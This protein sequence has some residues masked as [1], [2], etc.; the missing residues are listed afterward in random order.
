MKTHDKEK[1]ALQVIDMWLDYRSRLSTLPVPGFQICIRKKNRIVFSK[2]Y[3]YANLN[4]KRRQTTKD[5]YHIA[6]HSKTFTSCALLQLAEEG[7]LNLHQPALDYLPQLRHHKDKRFKQITIRDLL[8]HRSGIFRD[9]VDSDFFDLQKPF[10]SKEQL[11]QETLSSDLIFTPNECSKYS[12]IGYSLLGLVIENA[13]G[14]PYQKAMESLVLK[15]LKG[16]HILTDYSDN[17]KELFGDGHSRSLW[18][19]KRFPLKHAPA[20]AIAPAGGVCANAE[21]TSL[22]FETLLLGK[23]LLKKETQK[24][25]LSL[26]WPVKNAHRERY[27]LGLQFEKFPDMELVGHSG[28]YPG[29]ATYTTHGIGTDYVISFFLNTNEAVPLKSARSLIQIFNIINSTFTNDEAKQA[30]VE[31]PLMSMWGSFLFVLTKKK[32][33]RFSLGSWMPCKEAL[34]LASKNGE[35]FLCDKQDGYDSIGE[36]ITFKKDKDGNILSAKW[37]SGTYSLEKTFLEKFKKGLLLSS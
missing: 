36:R 27:G 2:A 20:L 14:M 11:I 29:F 3:G 17:S 13:L 1:L 15:K 26:N 9:G 8:S 21:D 32:G 10:L 18:E 6:S 4:T 30:R 7:K 12:N 28:G 33:L 24:E 16:A 37:G 31:G 25:L 34:L 22:F 19:G 23:G 35:E 5:L